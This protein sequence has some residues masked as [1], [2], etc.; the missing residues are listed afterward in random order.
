MYP[1]KII[2]LRRKRERKSF[3][4]SQFQKKRFAIGFFFIHPMCVCMFVFS[5]CGCLYCISKSYP[6]WKWSL[7][8]SLALHGALARERA[9]HCDPHKAE[10]I[11]KSP[12][13]EDRGAIP[14]VPVKEVC[15]LWVVQARRNQVGLRMERNPHER[16][17][18]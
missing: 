11:S 2:F 4:F 9:L 8:G 15:G 16:R 3:L 10:P 7:Y 6:S 13:S 5:S 12:N 14:R 18:V 17:N 1:V